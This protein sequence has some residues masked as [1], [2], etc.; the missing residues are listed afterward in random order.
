MATP[1]VTQKPN[2]NGAAQHAPE[3]TAATPAVDISTLNLYQRLARIIGELKP[4]AKEHRNEHFNYRYTGH[5]QIM[6]ELS[7]LLAKY[8]VLLVQNVEKFEE[9]ERGKTSSGRVIRLTRVW[10][11]YDVINADCPP[12]HFT[13]PIVADALDDQDK[14]FNKAS[15]AAD[16]YLCFR[17]FRIATPDSDPD[18]GGTDAK[19]ERRGR[20]QQQSQR[21]RAPQDAVANM[22][23][24]PCTR[25]G[26]GIID[27]TH[28]VK[29]KDPERIPWRRILEKAIAD[30]K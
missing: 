29:G 22:A 24:E 26:K 25:C 15:T 6:Q 19:E 10:Y 18:A 1:E 2:G 12:D 4:I 11:R 23:P 21:S 16:K 13:I 20:Q 27:L 30:F 14:G 3:P 8:G 5:D 28:K 7:P 17:L 9:A